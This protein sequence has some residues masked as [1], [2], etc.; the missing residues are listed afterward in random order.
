MGRAACASSTCSSC[1][2]PGSSTTLYAGLQSACAETRRIANFALHV[3]SETE[4]RHGGDGSPDADLPLVQHERDR[5][6]KSL[7]DLKEAAMK[8]VIFCGGQGMRMREASESIPKP[9]I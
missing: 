5:T 8:V 9:M 6:G 7:V 4:I 2:T 1:R 3:L